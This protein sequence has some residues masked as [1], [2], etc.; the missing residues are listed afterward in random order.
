MIAALGLAAAISTSRPPGIFPPKPAPPVYASGNYAL[1]FRA[2]PTLTYCPLPDG[3]VGSDHG[4][5]LFLVPPHECGGAGYASSSRAF[6]PSSTPRI[7]VYYGYAFDDERARPCKAAGRLRFLGQ[8]RP[9]CRDR[10]GDMITMEARGSYQADE[11]AEASV[12]LVTSPRRLSIDM[13]ALISLA[14]SLHPCRVPDATPPLGTG[15][16]CPQAAWY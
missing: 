3:W 15:A 8:T 9:L 11:P 14:K 5:T 6:S 16:A 2:S 10:D 12:R 7:E 13:K 4:T 1:T